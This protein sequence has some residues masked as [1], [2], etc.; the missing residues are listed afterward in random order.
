MPTGET[1]A[2][3][4]HCPQGHEYTPENT[5][6]RKDRPGRMCRTCM[7]NPAQRTR[8]RKPP[9]DF[10]PMYMTVDGVTTEIVLE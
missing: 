8:R 9:V 10:G 2:A 1:W 5:Y 7:R 3:K 6:N 4:T